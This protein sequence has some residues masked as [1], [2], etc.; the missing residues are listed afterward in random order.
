[1][2]DKAPAGTTRDDLVA[3]GGAR[4]DG[5][6]AIVPA[7]LGAAFRAESSAD[8]APTGEIT[9]YARI[10][11]RQPVR[12]IVSLVDK[13]QFRDPESRS[14]AMYTMPA[15]A[16]FGLGGQVSASGSARES[17]AAPRGSGSQALGCW[18]QVAM[19]V[20]RDPD[21]LVA[22]WYGR[23]ACPPNP[24]PAYQRMNGP[25]SLPKIERI[26]RNRLPLLIG[27]TIELRANPCELEFD[28]VRVYNRA[29]S[30]DEL[31]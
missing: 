13:R 31:P 2:A 15:G 21:R 7:K 6:A 24:P 23:P 18:A 20:R 16:G 30:V 28:E 17:L 26:F 29:L 9:I 25:V 12:G 5:G 19:I 27:N 3:L 1:L 14:Y 10:R 4:V 22:Q 11:I 8:L